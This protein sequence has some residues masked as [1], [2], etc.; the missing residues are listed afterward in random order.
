MAIGMGSGRAFSPESGM[1]ASSHHKRWSSREA[2]RPHVKEPPATS[3]L[4]RRT[5]V[6][7]EA[8]LKG[9]AR[10]TPEADCC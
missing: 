3:L 2:G 1:A 7:G 6:V 9:T 5:G 10:G 8:R 4:R